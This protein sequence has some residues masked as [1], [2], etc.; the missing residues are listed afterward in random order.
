VPAAGFVAEVLLTNPMFH[1]TDDVLLAA[2]QAPS[3]APL[4]AV[5]DRRGPSHDLAT[6]AVDRLG[7][8]AAAPVARTLLSRYGVAAADA[9]LAGYLDL[10]RPASARAVA[11]DLLGAL[12]AAIVPKVCQ[13]FGASPSRLDDEI[14]ALL[15]ALGSD[16]V[17]M[18][19]EAYA[20]RNFLERVG[21][22]LVRR[23]NHPRNTIVKV[24]ARIGGSEAH[25]AL[26]AL[27]TAET[28]PNLKLRIDQAL[29]VAGAT[30][31]LPAPNT[32]KGRRDEVG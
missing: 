9:L 13:C 29:Q 6:L 10:D 32:K 28:D 23:Y 3:P 14:V 2:A 26:S 18:L 7:D 19:L 16:A 24:L 22:R 25:A 27:R 8:E 20:R 5:L 17:P 4:L 31:A 21:G 15:V 12:G 11:R 30:R 1:R